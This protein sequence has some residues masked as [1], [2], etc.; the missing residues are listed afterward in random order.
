METTP[1]DAQAISFAIARDE[2]VEAIVELVQS[3]YRGDKSRKGWTTE[4]DFLDGQRVDSE[5]VQALIDGDAG[6]VLI[7]MRGG[8]LSGCCELS[9]MGEDLAYLGMFAVDPSQQ[10]GG[11]GRRILAEA[12]LYC[13]EQWGA[14]QL[15]ITVIDIRE[16]LIAWY[17]RQGFVRTGRVAPFPYGDERF[18]VPLRDDL[19]FVELIK[20]I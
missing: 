4:A 9:M 2:H 16:E 17:E 19:Q 6:V 5:M 13:Q 11:I 1:Q 18:G 10:A 20:K 15:S 12:Q 7:A 14:R 3:A 8:Q